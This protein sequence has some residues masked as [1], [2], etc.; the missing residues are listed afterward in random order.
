MLGYWEIWE[1]KY[2]WEEIKNILPSK[3]WVAIDDLPPQLVVCFS[4]MGNY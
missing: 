4:S 3:C 2:T 1:R